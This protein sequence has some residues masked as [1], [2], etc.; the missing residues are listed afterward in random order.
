MK[1]TKR[2]ILILTSIVALVFSFSQCM[3]SEETEF[4]TTD[5][6]Y[7]GTQTCIKCHKKVYDAFLV[8]P[9]SRASASIEKKDLLNGNH[10]AS[11]TYEFDEHFK[12]A[13]EDK[14]SGM[15]QTVYLDG[16]PEFSRRFD[17]AIGAGKNA[18]TYG[19]WNEN[20]L[21]QMQLSYFASINSWANSPG[22]PYNKIHFGRVITS[23]CLECHASQ[24]KQTVK[25]EGGLI[26]SEELVKGSLV[27]GINCERCHGP[28]AK[29]VEF[30]TKTPEA[31]PAKYVVKYQSLSRKQ[32]VDAC[33]ICHSGS[34]MTMKSTFGF[35]PGDQL[36][37]YGSN[38]AETVADPDVHGQQYQ[39]LSSSQ[40]YT[41][42]QQLDCSTCH[43]VH[44]QTKGSL[45]A[46]SKKC[47]SCHAT[48][49]HSE[50]TLSNAMVKTNCIDCHMPKQASKVISFQMAGKSEL[51]PYQLRSHLIK[52]YQ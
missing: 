52:I 5:S 47:M 36:E 2:L 35:R 12:I 23:R 45:T 44:D 16:I 25:E 3:N 50:Q 34:D 1:G 18:I 33:A 28:S 11:K 24:A 13:V 6:T 21:Y 46:Y 43:S 8:D 19:S 51:S 29:H 31:K 14:D 38:F 37:D 42:S 9:H 41:K 32:K 20:R 26:L 10:P 30:H 49:K 17:V 7:S 40:C 48:V 4:T 39:M 22:Y 15:Y 27:Y